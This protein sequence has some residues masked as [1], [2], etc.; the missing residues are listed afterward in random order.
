MVL[1][2]TVTHRSCQQD[3]GVPTLHGHMLSLKLRRQFPVRKRGL[4]LPQPWRT[5][6]SQA[7]GDNGQPGFSVA[8]STE[9]RQ[10]VPWGRWPLLRDTFRA[11]GTPPPFSGSISPPL[12]YVTFKERWKRIQHLQSAF[13]EPGHSCTFSYVAPTRPYKYED[14]RVQVERLRHRVGRSF[15]PGLG[16]ESSR[17]GIIERELFPR[18]VLPTTGKH[19][20]QAHRLPPCPALLLSGRWTETRKRGPCEGGQDSQGA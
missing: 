19:G 10:G 20:H 3:S 9:Q 13:P 14:P 17:S 6:G 8:Q 7:C 1:M 5:A 11:L 12:N 15:V 4:V 16:T 18:T 2:S